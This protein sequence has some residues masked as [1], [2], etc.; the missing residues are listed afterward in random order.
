MKNKSSCKLKKLYSEI[1]S[2][3]CYL[4]LLEVCTHRYRGLHDEGAAN[5]EEPDAQRG[6]SQ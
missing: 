1:A 4:L 2:Q 5:D 3:L 6:S